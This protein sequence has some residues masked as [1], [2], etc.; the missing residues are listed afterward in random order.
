MTDDSQSNYKRR[1][2]TDR[3][4]IREYN[5]VEVPLYWWCS[6]FRRKWAKGEFAY[7]KKL[8]ATVCWKHGSD[9]CGERWDI[10]VDKPHLPVLLREDTNS[11]DRYNDYL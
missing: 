8:G 3:F 10:Y 5:G 6:C 7:A 4:V 9:S 11:Q 1:N 2:E